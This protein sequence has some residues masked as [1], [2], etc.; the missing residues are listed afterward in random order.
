MKEY[1][2]DSISLIGAIGLGTGVMISAGIFALIGQITELSGS[3]FPFVFIIGSIV[4][5]ISS[6]SYIKFSQH[7]PSAGGIGKYLV[8]SYGK[9]VIASS[10]ALMMILSMVI[11]QSLVA[12]TFGTYTMQLFNGPTNSWIIPILGVS[13]LVFSLIVN[14]SGNFFIQTFTSIMSFVKIL[15]LLIFSFGGL[16]VSKFIFDLSGT[17]N[18]APDPSIMHYIAALALSILA[19]KGFTT[20]TNNGSEIKKPKVN[21]GRAIM[22]SIV[23]SLIVY[24]VIS[25]A[26][27][28]NLSVSEII[29]HKDYALAEAAKPA[30]GNLGLWF[31]V[32]LAIIATITAIIASVFAV[33]RLIAMLADMQ[34]IPHKNINDKIRTQQ[35][36]LFYTVGLAIILTI[37]FDLTRIA[38]LGAILYLTM[39]IVIHFGLV[40]KLK[41]EIDSKKTIIWTAIVLDIIILGAF[42][43]LK[44]TTDWLVVLVSILIIIGLLTMQKIFF[45]QQNKS[46]NDNNHKRNH[47]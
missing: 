40:S 23:I 29:A 38:S 19:F 5:A 16:Y 8:K 2:E 22:I 18:A 3:L 13:L 41:N 46:K 34:M 35:Q 1:K 43:Y 25:F 6:Y 39:D 21:V 4:T 37:L 27:S 28:G 12:R 47:E 7:Y 11:N 36:T 17:S 20:I 24:L 14:L 15:G 30:F 33:S 9:G 26:V 42:I 10:A 44:I 45:Y 31:T 32:I